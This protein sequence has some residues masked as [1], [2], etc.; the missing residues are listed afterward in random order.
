MN[1]RASPVLQSQPL[2]PLWPT[3]DPFLFC[4][5]HDD[6]YP[7]GNGAM[8]VQA[9]ALEGR[10]MGSDFSRKD[11][12]SMYHGE[13]VPG[14]PG[15]PHRGFETVTLVRKGLIDHADSLGAAARFGGGDVQWVTAGAGIMHS[16]MF[17]LLNTDA[18]NPLELFQIWLNLPARHKMVQPHFTMLWNERIPRLEHADAAGLRTTVTVV[19]GALDGAGAP[20]PPP[21]ESW[22]AQADADV[23]IWTLRMEPGAHWTL[24]AA[25]GQGTRRMLYW[26]VGEG[27]SIVGEPQGG[28]AALE[29]VADRALEL[30]NTGGDTVECLLLQGR[31]IGEPVVQYGPFVMNTQQEIMQAMQDFRRTQFGGWPWDASDPV[32]GSA[33]RRFARHPG[34]AQ[35]EVP[36]A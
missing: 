32:H 30:V 2:G 7:A 21:P 3:L 13:H 34:S 33:P 15:H 28:H 17:P 11:G 1:T 27:L 10:Q 16:E 9:V 36:Q 26:F 35:D 18:P 5:H 31:P 22:A 29:V 25:R 4:A 6:A 12:F 19:A 14:F 20:L 8:G 23:A 24:P